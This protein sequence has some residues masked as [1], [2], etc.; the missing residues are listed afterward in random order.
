[1]RSV[2]SKSQLG[3]ANLHLWGLEGAGVEV[4]LGIVWGK[5]MEL[6]F[7]HRKNCQ[8]IQS[9]VEGD[10]TSGEL[11]LLPRGSLVAQSLCLSGGLE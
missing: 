2:Q 10:G 11:V 9:I 3:T 1:M 4:G 8:M 7:V 5:H 6:V